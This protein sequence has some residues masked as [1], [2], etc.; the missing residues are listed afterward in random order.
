MVVPRF[1][2]ST[3]RWAVIANAWAHTCGAAAFCLA[4][5]GYGSIPCGYRLSPLENELTRLFLATI[6][7]T[8]HL[9][10][11]VVAPLSRLADLV[12]PFPFALSDW[13]RVGLAVWVDFQAWNIL[14]LVAWG[15][16]RRRVAVPI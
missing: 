15:L 8:E 14:L 10:H 13:T 16:S 5:Q 12:G 11:A 4:T 9:P 7:I 2:P 3:L 1:A 6:S